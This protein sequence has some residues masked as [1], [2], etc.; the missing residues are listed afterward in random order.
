M[1]SPQCKLVV[2]FLLTFGVVVWAG[3]SVD[4]S[5]SE[6]DMFACDDDDDCLDPDFVCGEQGFCD[7]PQFDTPNNNDDNDEEELVCDMGDPDYPPEEP[8]DID[9]VCDGT[10]TN[11]DGHIDIIFCDD[12]GECPGS[13]RD[14]EGTTLRFECNEELE[15]PQCEAFPPNTFEVGCNE[16]VPCDSSVGEYQE[17][18]EKCGGTAPNPSDNTGNNNNGNDGTNADGNGND[19]ANNGGDDEGEEGDDGG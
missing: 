12:E 5:A 14:P 6:P 19:A 15:P 1:R 9:E 7:E 3:C 10:D 4:F 2:A 13:T 8:L 11:C 16:P 18:F 17:V